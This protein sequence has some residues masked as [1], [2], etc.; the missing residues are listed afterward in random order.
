MLARAKN[1]VSC[2]GCSIGMWCW[3]GP[4]R[5]YFLFYKKTYIHIY[6][7]YLILKIFEH[8]VILVSRPA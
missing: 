8:D 6:N 7:L 4:T 5:L 2:L 3:P 1:A